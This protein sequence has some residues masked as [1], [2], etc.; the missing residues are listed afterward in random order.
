MCRSKLFSKKDKETTKKTNTKADV[1]KREMEILKEIQEMYEDMIDFNH[2]LEKSL[3]KRMDEMEDKMEEYENLKKFEEKDVVKPPISVVNIS[4]VEH[5]SP[6]NDN[7]DT[8]TQN[9][10]NVS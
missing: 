2:K 10:G 1:I 9:D 8:N 3:V 6:N 7:D 4:K 5:L